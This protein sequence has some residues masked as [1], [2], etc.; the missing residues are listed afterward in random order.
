M[1]TRFLKVCIILGLAVSNVAL[2]Q[3]KNKKPQPVAQNTSVDTLSSSRVGTDGP[4]L[5][6]DAGDAPAQKDERGTLKFSDGSLNPTSKKGTPE[7]IA[8]NDTAPDEQGFKSYLGYPAHEF[9]LLT[10]VDSISTTF[11]YQSKD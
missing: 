11:S 6:F 4:T 9:A 3:S 5:S 1:T 2:A 10:G 7:P 8:T